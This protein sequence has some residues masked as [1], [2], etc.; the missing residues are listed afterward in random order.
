MKT[1]LLSQIKGTVMIIFLALGFVSCNQE[2]LNP[3]NAESLVTANASGKKGKIDICHYS[4][5]DDQ[6]FVTSISENAWEEHSLHGDVW[7]DQDDDGHTIY[8]E[9]GVGTMDDCDDTDPSLYSDAPGL[10]SIS[11]SNISITPECYAPMSSFDS[12]YSID[13]TIIGLTEGDC[14]NLNPRLWLNG[15]E[16]SVYNSFWFA[17]KLILY[18]PLLKVPGNVKVNVE[19]GPCMQAESSYT[20][21]ACILPY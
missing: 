9:C 18:I 20:A 13:I 12:R 21:P 3:N 5:K 17:G 11:I 15:N 16:R 7:L 14:N 4:V 10:S 8:N 2:E 19:L 1:R 6:W